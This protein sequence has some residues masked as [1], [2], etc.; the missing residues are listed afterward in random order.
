VINPA[1]NLLQF[2]GIVLTGSHLINTPGVVAKRQTEEEEEEGVGMSSM[3]RSREKRKTKK[4]TN[5]LE[6][7]IQLLQFLIDKV[8]G[9]FHLVFGTILNR[10]QAKKNQPWDQHQR[11][12][13]R[14]NKKSLTLAAG[15][16]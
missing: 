5:P 4:A 8:N 1:P 7:R 11:R 16:S 9:G 12:R 3:Q 15:N 6:P 13:R 2:S 14:R 10:N